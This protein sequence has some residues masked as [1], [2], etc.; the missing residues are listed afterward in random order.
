[1]SWRV[2]L[3]ELVVTDDDLAA[4]AD[5]LRSGWLTMGPRTREFEAALADWC[6]TEHA[7]AVSSGS[8]AL[9]LACAALDLGPG[10]EVI[11][12]ALTFLSSAHAARHRGAD[13]VLCDVASPEEPNIDVA[14][15]ERRITE[16]T[17]AVVATHMFG[18][19]ANVEQLRA[20]CDDRGLALVEDA[21]EALGARLADGATA[22]TRGELGCL[23]FF[24]KSQLPLGEGGAVLTRD[25]ALADRVRLL[26]SHAMTS[27]T[28]DRH[29]G[30]TDTYD[31]VDIGFNFRLDEP[32]ASLGL[33]RLRRLDDELE[34]RRAAVRLYRRLLS[35]V[36]GVQLMWTDEA[37]EAGSHY[38]FPV[39]FESEE[40][41]DRVRAE[42]TEQGIETTRYP[43]L[44]L[45]TV[46][47]GHGAPGAFPN[48]EAAAARH[49]ALPISAHL[50]P[51]T[52]ETVVG[53]IA[54]AA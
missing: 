17:R 4:V 40:I 6:G 3:T 37:A 15:V 39:L 42:L 12:P 36:G 32:R 52:V 8:A 26:R 5:C 29:H 24:S 25:E 43:V 1:M 41:R 48:A 47:A 34:A 33:S 13:V 46:Y 50:T 49:L 30:Y 54:A 19:V 31:V 18:Y 28:W 16:R 14:D 44:H 35:T 10:D 53:A 20:L 23:S 22:G 38:A 11:V 27:G 45:L 2:P 9:D 7:I 51:E 21:A